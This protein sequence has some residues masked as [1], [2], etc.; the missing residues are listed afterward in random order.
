[1]TYVFSSVSGSWNERHFKSLKHAIPSLRPS[2]STAFTR[3]CSLCR[4]TVVRCFQQNFPANSI[5]ELVP[6]SRNNGYG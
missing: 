4:D 6:G 2:L 3:A 1:M 5:S